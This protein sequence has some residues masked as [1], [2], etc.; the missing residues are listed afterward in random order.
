MP[1][2]DPADRVPLGR[3]PPVELVEVLVATGDLRP[4]VPLLRA[5]GGPEH[6]RQALCLLGALD[7]DLL[8]QVALNTLIADYVDDP[9]VAEQLRLEVRGD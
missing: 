6:A 9:A 7:A 4:L 8:V 3:Q 5:D 2:E 1:M